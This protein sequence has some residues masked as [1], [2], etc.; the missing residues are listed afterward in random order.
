[1]SRSPIDAPFGAVLFLTAPPPRAPL[2]RAA[3]GHLDAEPMEIDGLGEAAAAIAALQPL[4]ILASDLRRDATVADRLG[5]ATGAP[6]AFDRRLR[7]RSFGTWQGRS[8]T[9]LVVNEPA[10]VA[11]LEHFDTAAPPGGETTTDVATRA[12]AP[13]RELLMKK[14]RQT[15]AVVA[16]PTVVRAVLADALAL[17]HGATSRWRLDPLSTTGLRFEGR[18]ATLAWVNRFGAAL[19]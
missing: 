16:A 15:I 19:F 8:W 18:F 10:A 14:H 7:D 5:D 4:T 11:F 17:P 6:V 13:I 9:D 1:M 3:V 12:G 2:D